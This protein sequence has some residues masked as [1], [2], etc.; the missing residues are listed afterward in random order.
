[1]EEIARPF[2]SIIM[3]VLNSGATIGR[4]LESLTQQI[5]TDFELIIIDGESTDSTLAEIRKF[6]SR[7]PISHL[8]SEPDEGLYDALNKGI[9][10]ARGEVVASLN[11]DDCYAN[12]GVLLWYRE[13][14]SEPIPDLVFADLVYFS[15]ARPEKVR[16]FYSSREFLPEKLKKGWMPPHPTVFVRAEVYHR[17][18]TYRTDYQIAADYEFLVRALLVNRLSYRRIDAVVVR[19]QLGGLSTSGLSATFTLNREILRSLRENGIQGSWPGLLSKF[20]TKI[21]ELFASP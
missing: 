17:I 19:M 20:P 16:R 5:F 9:A 13:A 21:K 11:G 2:F 4:A 6:E 15:P 7:L 1:M 8:V 14:F 10:R 18:G 3:P 12:P